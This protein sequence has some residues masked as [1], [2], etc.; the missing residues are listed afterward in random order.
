MPDIVRDNQVQSNFERKQV[1]YHQLNHIHPK[2]LSIQQI[3]PKVQTINN[4]K[5]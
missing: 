5:K 2:S 4:N 3:F 1:I